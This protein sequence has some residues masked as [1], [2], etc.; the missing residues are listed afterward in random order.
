[1]ERLNLTLSPVGVGFERFLYLLCPLRM[2][3]YVLE[4][5]ASSYLCRRT[6]L[7]VSLLC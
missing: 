6:L 2:D 4:A 7:R 5:A 1:M 3:S